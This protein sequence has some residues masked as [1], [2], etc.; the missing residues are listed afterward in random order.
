MA[1]RARQ[2]AA[3]RRWPGDRVGREVHGAK[4]FF[5]QHFAG[6]HRREF[7]GHVGMPSLVIID[8]L[9]LFR[10]SVCPL[11]YD[12]PLIV[13]ADRMLS[14][15]ISPQRFQAISWRSGEIAQQDGTVELHQFAASDLCDVR[16]EPLRNASLLEDQ[17]GK[18]SAETPDHCQL[19]IIP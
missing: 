9:D 18:R 2:P 19:R 7:L 1:D 12:S 10:S 6:V 8:D 4:E 16:R 15:E 13:Y 14:C 17:L 5:A 11:K 3:Q